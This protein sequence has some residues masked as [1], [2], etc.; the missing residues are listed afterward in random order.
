MN[1]LD[2]FNMLWDTPGKDSCD[3]MPLGN[4]DIGLN[5]WI[6]Q[7]GDLLFYISKTD[8]WNENMR[9][10]KLGRIRVKLC[11]NPF[12]EGG[13]FSQELKLVD[14]AV[15]INAGEANVKIKIWVDANNPA[16]YVCIQSQTALEAQVFLELWRKGERI[17]DGQELH[18]SYTMYDC[19]EPVVEYS[20]TILEGQADSI[21]WYH[22]NEHSIWPVTMKLQGLEEYMA[23]SRDPLLHRTFGGII[24]GE[25]LSPDN[26][27]TLKSIRPLNQFTLA[28]YPMTMQTETA[29][30]WLVQIK[31][32][33]EN[34]KSR[35][36]DDVWAAHV[37]WWEKFWERSYV[38]ASGD[39]GAEAVTRGYTLQRYM[40]A[41]GGRGAYPIKFNGS[42]FTMDTCEDMSKT[43]Y[44][45]DYRRWGGPYW[46]QNTRLLYWAL[47]SSGDFDL[48]KPLFKMY[49]DALA[50]AEFRT[51]K[52]YGHKGVF[53]PETMCFWGTYANNDYGWNRAGKPL[54]SADNM[55]IKYYWQ[56]TLELCTMMLDYYHYTQDEEFLKS[57]LMPLA[58]GVIEFYDHHYP[59]D[60]KGKIKFEPAASLET[61]HAVINPLPEIAGLKYVIERLLSLPDEFVQGE[62]KTDWG[63][64][65]NELPQMPKSREGDNEF[66]LPTEKILD[67]Q[68]KNSEN[69][70]L[71]AV[72]PY[73]LY[74]V[75]MPELEVAR[76]TFE[77]RT[78]KE[79]CGWRQDAIQ[80]AFLGLADVARDYIVHNFST[81]SK[82]YRF[83]AFWGP[84]F[85]WVPDQD[86]GSV[87]S[88]ALQAMLIQ[89]EGKNIMLFPAWPED[90]DVEFKLFTGN[91]TTVE[92]EYKEGKLKRLEVSPKERRKDVVV[93]GD[94]A[95][96]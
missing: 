92:C 12:I 8:A 38:Y 45:A 30:E 16:A 44:D 3:S 88:M 80:A 71:Y 20:D 32:S 34:I 4:G 9:L 21:A 17:L 84:N 70:E 49:V 28:I 42:I 7:N 83:P 55:Y 1:K 15:E 27:T 86:H 57:T 85:D 58:N 24:Q 62:Q 50:L 35:S 33:I 22:R 96:I 14:G 94:A 66:L 89:T 11:P 6:E 47:L 36:I 5:V 76:N 82:E 43:V 51:K 73:R 31:E 10:L 64:I 61:W 13:C 29:D 63:R 56:G 25:G 23:Q 54:G 39:D 40:N 78:F 91:N 67:E 65:L 81:S 79:S 90:W 53:F 69:P 52:Y 93:M 2:K 26:A 59:R 68:I 18:S 95:C 37:E 48:M 60:E 75:G 41:C 19:P 74:G 46:F 87:A 72:F 77:R